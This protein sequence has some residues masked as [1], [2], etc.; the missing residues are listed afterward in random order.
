[1][2]KKPSLGKDCVAGEQIGSFTTGDKVRSM[3]G[4]VTRGVN[5]ADTQPPDLA[6]ISGCHRVINRAGRKVIIRRKNAGCLSRVKLRHIVVGI[7]KCVSY[8]C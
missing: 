2:E 6:N 7:L 3:S 5:V 1:M 4:A 8:P